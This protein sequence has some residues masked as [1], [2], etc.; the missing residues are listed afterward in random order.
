M[1]KVFLILFVAALGITGC[2]T[3]KEGQ[4]TGDSTMTDSTM[5]NGTAGNT[6]SDTS[7]AAV[8]TAGKTMSDTTAKP[9]L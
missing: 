6:M 2:S 7:K 1:K 4:S 9:P 3:S 5:T 8:D